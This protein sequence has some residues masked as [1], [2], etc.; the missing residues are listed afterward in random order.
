MITLQIINYLITNSGYSYN[1]I[2]TLYSLIT[3]SLVTSFCIYIQ[4]LNI[5]KMK[6]NKIIIDFLPSMYESEI[7]S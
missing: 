6:Y 7:F 5:K 4:D 1:Y 3:I 2:F